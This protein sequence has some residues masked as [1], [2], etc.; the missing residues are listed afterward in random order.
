MRILI[1]S[2]LLALAARGLSQEQYGK[3]LL[4][5]SELAR[6]S[7]HHDTIISALG[8]LYKQEKKENAPGKYQPQRI[9]LVRQY[10]LI[11]Q[12][13][14]RQ[15]EFVY[16]SK[17]DVVAIVGKPDSSYEEDGFQVY[18]YRSLKSKFVSLKNINYNMVF[19]N[20]ELVFVKQQQAN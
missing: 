15:H 20:N 1:L 5:V 4:T 2:I 10:I 19:K 7:Y 9:E 6:M 16:Y 11:F 18:E 8:R 17:S 13:I 12:Q 3:R 14:E